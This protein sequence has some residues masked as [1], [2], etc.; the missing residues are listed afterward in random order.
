MDTGIAGE[1][2]T[3]GNTTQQ[4]L[5]LRDGKNVLW[6]SRKTFKTS[7][8]PPRKHLEA[9]NHTRKQDTQKLNKI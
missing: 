6:P 7:Q 5:I 8:N 2:T 9:L 4:A 1:M 3:V